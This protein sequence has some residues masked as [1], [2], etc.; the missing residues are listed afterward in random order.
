MSVW[1]PE[2]LDGWIDKDRQGSDGR[3]LARWILGL[4]NGEWMA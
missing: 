1:V 2:Q 4:M 3:W